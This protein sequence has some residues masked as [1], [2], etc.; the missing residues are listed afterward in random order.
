[1]TERCLRF[2]S[3]GLVVT[4]FQCCWVVKIIQSEFIVYVRV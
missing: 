1:M 4:V 2:V 3:I